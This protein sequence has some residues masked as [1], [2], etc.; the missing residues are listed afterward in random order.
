MKEALSS[1]FFLAAAGALLWGFDY[2]QKSDQS[3][4]DDRPS[5]GAL[6]T[7]P[8]IA[9]TEESDQ[10]V[11]SSEA[12]QST[13]EKKPDSGITSELKS[14]LDVKVFNGGAPKGSAV[15]VQDFLK[16][17]GYVKV[18]AISAVGDYTGTTVYYLGANEA[19][20]TAIQQ[21]LLADFPKTEVKLATSSTAENG[22]ASV[23]VMLGK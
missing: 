21:L 4:Q 14:S 9:I 1:I 11:D 22:S 16:K 2:W 15:K 7:A 19:N 10:S 23:V 17:N 18:Q 12:P 8:P 3:A 20:A 13:E 5:I 6:A